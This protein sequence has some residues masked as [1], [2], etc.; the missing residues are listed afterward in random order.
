MFKNYEKIS[1]DV[2]YIIEI[3]EEEKNGRT[4]YLK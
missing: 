1:K 2:T 3:L 4:E